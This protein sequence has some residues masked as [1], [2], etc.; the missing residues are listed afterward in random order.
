MPKL[1]A[2]LSMLFTEVDFWDRFAAARRE[3]FRAV[4]M[5]FPYEFDVSEIA[6]RLRAENL[7]LVLF[8]TSPGDFAKGERGLAALTGREQEFR[9]KFE[10]CLD[11]ASALSC[12]RLHI[13]AGVVPGDADPVEHRRCFLA[14]L[15]WA[16]GVAKSKGIDLLL[17]PLNA[18]DVPRYLIPTIAD[19]V[20]ILEELRFDNLF[21]QF[22]A[23]H[24]QMS[25]GRLTD[26][27]NTHFSRIRHVQ[28]SGVPG[29]HEPDDR[30]EINFP[31]L[32]RQ[33]DELGYDGW[34]GCEYRPRSD[35]C[36]GLGWAKPWLA[37]YK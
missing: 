29:R 10:L 17:E 21:L 8:N 19:A 31:H 32:L 34:V 9:Q 36:S 2:N 25:E 13:M 18:H 16:A 37:L 30:Q 11:Y 28:I 3:G 12:R 27:L 14:N 35:T 23:Y 26:K 33:L 22:D 15:R 4:E 6:R 24:A 1:A 7:E 5:L 20:S